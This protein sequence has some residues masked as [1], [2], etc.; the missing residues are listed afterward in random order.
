MCSVSCV[1]LCVC[2]WA[3]CTCIRWMN[4]WKISVSVSTQEIV[5]CVWGSRSIANAYAYTFVYLCRRTLSLRCLLLLLCTN[6]EY[7]PMNIRR[8]LHHL[9]NTCVLCACFVLC[10]MYVRVGGCSRICVS[11]WTRKHGVYIM[12]GGGMTPA[13]AWARWRDVLFDMTCQICDV[14]VVVVNGS[15]ASATQRVFT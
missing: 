14:V 11:A 10:T 8:T 4:W 1:R 9:Y 12:R 6:T 2:L 7:L 15:A 13:C 3:S 5:D